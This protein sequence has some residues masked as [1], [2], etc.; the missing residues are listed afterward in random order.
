V[1]ILRQ[2]GNAIDAAV[3][4][5]YA[6]AVVNPCCGN[7]GGGG[8]LTAHLDDGRD[9]FLNFRETAPESATR[10]MYLDPNGQP[11][12]GASLHGWKAVAVPGTVLGLDTALMKYGTMPRATVMQAAI[13]LA[14]DGFV[15]TTADADILALGAPLL[16][17]NPTA[18]RIFLRPGLSPLQ[19]GDRLRQPELA[20][21]LQA[22]ADHGPDAFYKGDI[23]QAVEAASRAGGGL[24]TA[25]DFA[26]YRVTES[27]PLTCTYRGYTIES[28]PPPSSGGTAICETLNILGGYDLRAMGFHSAGAV[29]V[30]TEAFRHAFFDRNTYLGDPAFVHAPL[31]RL[32]SKTYAARLRET[33]GDK[34][35]PSAS[36]GPAIP[37]A[38]EKRETTHFSILDK[39]GGAASV[40]YTLNGGFGAGVIAGNTGFLLNDEMDDFTLKPNVP[41]Q[42]GLVQGEA[43]AI[44]PGKRPLSS[45]APTIVLKNGSVEMVLGSP[46]GPRIITAIIETILNVLDYGM[47]AQEAVDAPRLHHQWLPDVLY[48]EPFALSPDTRAMLQGMGYH[49]QLQRPS[50]AVELIASG[51]LESKRSSSSSGAD[52]VATH[53]PRPDEFYGANDSR[54]P[55]GV[56][57]AP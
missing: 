4:V 54:R 26:A 47:N 10:D 48:A 45:M 2:G 57:L 43:N 3:A 19:A 34:A 14:R 24:I 23:P 12:P 5:G 39:A 33:I 21:T 37:S 49:I 50:G 52:S 16:R 44:A 22:I 13:R 20:A 53:T 7:I 27:P 17:Q 36:L 35:T 8:F 40:T 30:M 55:A 51:P 38:E 15:L 31:T 18:G 32:L 9:I 11:V 56:A 41:N 6:E 1:E 25:A 46:G 29:H 42:F 28:A